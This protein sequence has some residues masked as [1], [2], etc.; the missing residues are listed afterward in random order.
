MDKLWFFAKDGSTDRKGPIPENELRSLI[1]AGQIGPADLVWT[2]GMPSWLP[3][4][5]LPQMLP[6]GAAAG[7]TPAAPGSPLPEG[8]HGWMV[9]VGIMS[10]FCGVLTIL[11]CVGIIPGIFMLIAGSALV[12][13]ANAL[14]RDA[15]VSPSLEI[16]FRKLKSF[17][18]MSGV[19]Y[20]L[21]TVFTLVG[22]L[23]VFGLMA[24]GFGHF[25]KLP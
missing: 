6:G 13:A 3:L 17:M 2:E 19:A 16:F 11:S 1:S 24:A 23:A 15:P 18:L 14:D 7:P 8:L 4:R 5:T 10:I 12:S 20:I 21:G 9:F 25:F 22:L